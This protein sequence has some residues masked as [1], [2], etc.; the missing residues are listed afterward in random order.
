MKV[1]RR[2][3]IRL[4]PRRA[5]VRHPLLSEISRINRSTHRYQLVG[6]GGI[7]ARL[8]C[9]G[10]SRNTV[11][12]IADQVFAEGSRVAGPVRNAR[13]RDAL[14]VQTRR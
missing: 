1:L 13:N 10:G 12:E 4:Q 3:V 5:D 11:I 2:R 7:R 6:R 8:K 9:V 14:G